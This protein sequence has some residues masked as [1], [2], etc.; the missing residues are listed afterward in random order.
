VDW[1]YV[2]MMR[3]SSETIVCA[4]PFRAYDERVDRL[5]A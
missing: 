5:A 4:D 2:R 3:P 1:A